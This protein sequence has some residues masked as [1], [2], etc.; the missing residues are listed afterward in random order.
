VTAGH[1]RTAREK[2]PTAYAPVVGFFVMLGSVEAVRRY[3][4]RSDLLEDYER[5]ASQTGRH[6]AGTAPD[7]DPEMITTGPSPRARLLCNRL[8]ET[9]ISQLILSYHAGAT[10]KELAERYD[11]GM[12]SL[13]RLLR[14]RKVRRCDIG[15]AQ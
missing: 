1:N 8:S 7:D 9:D 12:T 10:I 15:K 11:I 3:A 6:P 14:E 5:A 2:P 4:N 13:K